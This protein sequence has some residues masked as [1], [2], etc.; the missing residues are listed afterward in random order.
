MWSTIIKIVYFLLSGVTYGCSV[1]VEGSLSSSKGAKQSLEFKASSVKVQGSCDPVVNS[2]T[3]TR[4][5]ISKKKFTI[6]KI[7]YT[8]KRLVVWHIQTNTAPVFG[9]AFVE[10]QTVWVCISHPTDRISVYYFPNLVI[11][12][13][14]NNEHQRIDDVSTDCISYGIQSLETMGFA[15]WLINCLIVLSKRHN[16]RLSL[17]W[18]AVVNCMT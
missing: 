17:W 14:D 15:M 13:V 5:N 12:P 16:D 9:Q 6:C 11:M 8:L 18:H 1:E 10:K 3:L 2:L 4:Q 7:Y